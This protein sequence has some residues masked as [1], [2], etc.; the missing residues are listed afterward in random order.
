MA[1]RKGKSKRFNYSRVG[2]GPKSFGNSKPKHKIRSVPYTDKLRSYGW[3]KPRRGY[4][5][6]KT[7]GHDFYRQINL[8]TGSPAKS[9]GRVKL[10][11]KFATTA[12]SLAYYEKKFP[13]F[14]VFLEGQEKH[15]IR[16]GRM[17]KL[18]RN[19]LKKWERGEVKRKPRI[20]EKPVKLPEGEE[21]EEKTQEP[22][23]VG[24]AYKIQDKKEKAGFSIWQVGQPSVSVP[25]QKNLKF[26]YTF[27]DGSTQESPRYEKRTKAEIHQFKMR[28]T[29]G[30]G[31]IFTP[32]AD[33]RTTPIH[34]S[35][36]R[37]GPGSGIETTRQ[38]VSK[39]LHGLKI[40]SKGN[41]KIAFDWRVYEG[42]HKG[43]RELKGKSG[44]YFSFNPAKASKAFSKFY[45]RIVNEKLAEAVNK[46]FRPSYA[47]RNG[48][49]REEEDKITL[50]NAKLSGRSRAALVK[51][52][53]VAG[54]I[55]HSALALFFETQI[56]K[57]AK[58]R[59]VVIS[60]GS[61]FKHMHG[62]EKGLRSATKE[63]W[64]S[65]FTL[66]LMKA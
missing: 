49:S 12:K 42:L 10:F 6:Q 4:G 16:F 61:E 11:S 47:D 5:Y 63:G 65:Q 46:K 33:N 25:Q 22:F 20:L 60:G 44:A 53:K 3:P 29:K 37:I 66:N 35:T 54:K 8:K 27:S 57:A 45:H 7:V 36:E 38:L 2:N 40:P 13:D 48:I 24:K 26:V 50:K 59:G 9:R 15:P 34:S 43:A 62:K 51:Q 21:F 17:A 30:R 19:A 14:E 23:I 32:G 58:A 18:E 28:K 64:E 56:L 52:L 31:T 41:L 55:P 1:K 39:A